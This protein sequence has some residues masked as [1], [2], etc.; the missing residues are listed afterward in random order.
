MSTFGTCDK[1]GADLV[2]ACPEC[3]KPVEVYSRIVGY[4]RPVSNWNCGKQQEFADRK[5]FVIGQGDHQ[6]IT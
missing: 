5:T 4:M 6:E 1:C 3:G 2:S